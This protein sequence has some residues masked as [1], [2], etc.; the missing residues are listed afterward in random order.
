MTAEEPRLPPELEHEIFATAA[1][2]HKKSIPKL[3]LVAH[4]VHVWY[5]VPHCFVM[6]IALT[7]LRI[8]PYLYRSLDL[9]VLAQNQALLDVSSAKPASFLASAVRHVIFKI[10]E[11]FEAHTSA[12]RLCT[13]ITHFA[14]SGAND[15]NDGLLAILSLMRI[16]RFAGS[17]VNLFDQPPERPIDGRHP[18]FRL[19]THLEFFD[20]DDL[21]MFIVSLPS[22]T[23]LATESVLSGEQVRR[24]FKGCSNLRVMVLL[25]LLGG[26]PPVDDPRIVMCHYTEWSEAAAPAPQRT[27]WDVAEA[28]LEKKRRGEVQGAQYCLSFPDPD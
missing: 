2:L 6:P 8:E 16:E 9:S 19:L 7:M 4:R 26:V 25:V 15:T 5:A 23:H 10:D 21:E 12:L 17:I 20:H 22:L 18:A 13:G 24:L 11:D 28:F 27:F 3:L 14:V 1:L